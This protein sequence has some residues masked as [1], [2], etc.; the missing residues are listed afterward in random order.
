MQDSE[1]DSVWIQLQT[2]AAV[3]DRELDVRLTGEAGMSSTQFQALWYLANAVDRSMTMSGIAERLS[4]SASGMTRLADRLV[5]KGWAIRRQDPTSR[6]VSLLCLTQ[7]GTA[8]ARTGYQVARAVRAELLDA[9]LDDDD[10]ATL[11]ILLD[12][13]LGHLGLIDVSR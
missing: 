1:R 3:L 8:A 7:K 2:A 13:L 4:M 5:H 11:S 10:A 6:R 12:K 9:R